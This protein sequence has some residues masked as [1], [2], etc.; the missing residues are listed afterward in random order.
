MCYSNILFKTVIHAPHCNFCISFVGRVRNL[1][2]M[3]G[4][5]DPPSLTTQHGNILNQLEH[6]S[7]LFKKIRATLISLSSVETSSE[8]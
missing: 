8:S 4:V 5:H 1:N 3:T 7:L 2:I 6:I